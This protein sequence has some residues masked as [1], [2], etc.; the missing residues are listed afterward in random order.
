MAKI[1]KSI[2][3]L[4]MLCIAGIL[5]QCPIFSFALGA[6]QLVSELPVKQTDGASPLAKDIDNTHIVATT[7]Q[8]KFKANDMQIWNALTD[9]KKYPLFFKRI[10]SVEI[11]KRDGNFI[12][13]ECQ[14]RRS[15]F[16]KTIMQHTINDLSAGPKILN[17]HMVDGNFKYLKGKWELV[18]QSPGVCAVI[19]RLWPDSASPISQFRCALYSTR[20]C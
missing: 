4:A 8:T 3:L 14:L 7:M 5:I 11:T 19:C 15:L 18:Q 20:N 17:W 13:T 1:K 6:P 9:F 16:V 10:Q 2:L 12:Y